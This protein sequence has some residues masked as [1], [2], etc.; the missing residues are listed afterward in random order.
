MKKD[1]NNS[2]FSIILAITMTGFM[3]VL[4][5]GIFLLVL[6]ENKD[7]K[8][9]ENYFKSSQGAE[10]SLELAMLK[11]KQYNYSYDEK[12]I[13]SN[14]LSKILCK[15][16]TNCYENKDELITY[17]LSSISSQIVDKKI[18]LGNFDIIPLF[19]YDQ[20]GVYKKVKN[21]TITGLNNNIIWNIV[22]KDSGISGIGDFINTTEGNYKTISGL[23]ISYNKKTI[24]EFLNFSDYNYLIL[25]NL[26]NG[27]ITYTLKSLNSGE[28]LT[29]DTSQI[30]ATGEV[31]GFKQ[32]LIVNINSSKYLNLL[33]YSIFSN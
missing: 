20:N 5:A 11:A 32:N 15:D 24:G 31:G 25:H 27:E 18:E 1:I 29:K 21:I 26:S 23:D 9:I 12:L 16:I 28:F 7:T 22:G 2:G 33:K 30:I 8:S 10:G 13:S 4:T 14:S 17:N 3:I 19:S 6:S